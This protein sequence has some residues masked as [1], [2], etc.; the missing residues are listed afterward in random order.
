MIDPSETELRGSWITRDTGVVADE[1]TVRIENLVA[2]HLRL[3]QA[4]SDG[5]RAV[6]EDPSDG[7]RWE[8]TFPE[9][10]RHGGGPP[11]LQCLD[12]EKRT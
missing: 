11:M 7:R 6:Y 3:I 10:E 2:R 5:W 9:S 4:S 8:L 12:A 1:V